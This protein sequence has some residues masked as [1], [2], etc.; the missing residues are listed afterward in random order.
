MNVNERV[1]GK[2]N[3][4]AAHPSQKGWKLLPSSHHFTLS[5]VLAFPSQTPLEVASVESEPSCHSLEA[6]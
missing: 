3:E 1:P 4:A 5:F 6:D 2:Q